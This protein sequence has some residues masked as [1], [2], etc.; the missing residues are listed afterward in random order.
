M[1]SLSVQESGVRARIDES[2]LLLQSLIAD[3]GEFDR[4][5]LQPQL[6]KEADVSR[7]QWDAASVTHRRWVKTL[8]GKWKLGIQAV[9]VW[10]GHCCS[11]LYLLHNRLC[12]IH[13]NHIVD[14]PTAG[15]GKSIIRRDAYG[16]RSRKVVVPKSP[17]KYV[18]SM[19]LWLS[20]KS[21]RIM[22]TVLIL[23]FSTQI[24]N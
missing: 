10:C 13:L 19:I 20:Q 8:Q 21:N 9:C 6:Q 11:V 4:S 24:E 5:L 18:Q 3:C 2:P 1:W 15:S 14:L 23:S 12:Q 22:L 16:T 17:L 7:A